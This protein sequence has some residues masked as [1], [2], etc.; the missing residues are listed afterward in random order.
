MALSAGF[1]LSEV[2]M[3]ALDALTGYG[4]DAFIKVFKTQLGAHYMRDH[5]A[6]L[7]SF[8]ATVRREVLPALGDIDRARRDLADAIRLRNKREE[9]HDRG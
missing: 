7:R 5:E 4:D 6:G 8:F 1:K 9:E 3:R 2:E